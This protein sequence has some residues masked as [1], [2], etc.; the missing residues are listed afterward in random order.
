MQKAIFLKDPIPVSFEGWKEATCKEASH[1]A[2]MKLAGMFQNQDQKAGGF[3]FQNPKAQQRWGKFTQSN[4]N[5]N[6]KRDPNTMDV[7]TIRV[8]KV[9]WP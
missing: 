4:Q 3:K 7:D 6:A 1:Y 5:T 8:V 9:Q 2:L